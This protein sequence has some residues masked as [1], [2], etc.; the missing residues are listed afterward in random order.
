MAVPNSNEQTD[1]IAGDLRSD[2]SHPSPKF[3]KIIAF[4]DLCRCGEEV[5]NEHLDSHF[6]NYSNAGILIALSE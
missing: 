6:R 2:A 5:W 3:P 1:A 4:G